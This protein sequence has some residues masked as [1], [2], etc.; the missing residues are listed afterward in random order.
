MIK[1]VDSPQ[2][3]EFILYSLAS[4][5]TVLGEFVDHL[6]WNPSKNSWPMLGVILHERDRVHPGRR[7]VVYS[8]G[9]RMGVSSVT[10]CGLVA[11]NSIVTLR[12]QK[13]LNWFAKRGSIHTIHT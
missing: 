8:R 11:T 3:S 1:A 13:R 7:L 5:K 10:G 2:N 12:Y 6:V 4:E 9:C